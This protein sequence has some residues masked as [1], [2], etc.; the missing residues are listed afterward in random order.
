MKYSTK[1][2]LAATL[3]LTVSAY[4]QDEEDAVELGWSGTGEFGFVS[5]TGNTETV[6]LNGKLN[7]VLQRE[8]WRHR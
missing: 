2:V 8:R 1:T 6:A 7:F 5:T 3:L 4:A